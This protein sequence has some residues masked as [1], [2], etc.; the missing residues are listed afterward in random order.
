MFDLLRADP[1]VSVGGSTIAA[2]APAA[3]E[4]S[5]A[6]SIGMSA[7]SGSARGL[8]VSLAD[9]VLVEESILGWERLEFE[10]VRDAKDQMTAVC[11]IQSYHASIG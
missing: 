5:T 2:I 8:Q 7:R 10:V 11:F 9:Q 3:F 1:G 4:H 6:A